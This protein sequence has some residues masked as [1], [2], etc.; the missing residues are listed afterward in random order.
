MAFLLRY[1]KLITAGVISA[2]LVALY[3]IFFA[4]DDVRYFIID[5]IKFENS[6]SVT[7]I[8][9]WLQA[10]ES[11]ISNPMGIGLATS[12]NAGGVEKDLQIGGENQYLIYGVQL[13]FL[14]LILYVGM[15]LKGIIQS[16]KAYRTSEKRTDAIV[17]FIGA[18]VKFGLLLPLFTANAEAYLYVSLISWW[19]I[20][21]GESVYQRNQAEKKSLIFDTNVISL[22]PKV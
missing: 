19:M 4:S 21:Y 11:M 10:V 12:G 5:T 3:V 2:V 15:L 7:H 14:G 22:Q 13:G 8:I 6:S 16:W 17:P 20:G 18:S 9:E 1:Y